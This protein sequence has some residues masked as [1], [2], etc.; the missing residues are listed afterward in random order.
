M[1]LQ[2]EICTEKDGEKY[3]INKRKRWIDDIVIE[4]ELEGEIWIDEK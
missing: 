4:Y 2:R 1:C 3:V